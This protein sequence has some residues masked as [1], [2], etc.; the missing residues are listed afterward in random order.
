MEA[1]AANAELPLADA[2]AAIANVAFDTYTRDHRLLDALWSMPTVARRI[3]HR[4]G[5]VLVLAAIRE[6]LLA[7]DAELGDRDPELVAYTC[8]HMA[9]ALVNQMVSLRA[10]PWSTE[11]CVAEVTLALTRYLGLE[12]PA[13][14]RGTP[15]LRR[16][17]RSR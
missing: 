2:I 7:G 1:F 9:D 16:S 17:K 14:A 6:R 3:G 4:P 8:F 12:D 5:E 15:R 13:L 10:R 11:A